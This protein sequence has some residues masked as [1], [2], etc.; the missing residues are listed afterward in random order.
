LCINNITKGPYSNHLNVNSNQTD[1]EGL[2]S[3]RQRKISTKVKDQSTE[4]KVTVYNEQQSTQ[5]TYHVWQ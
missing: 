3:L 2:E 4:R 5:T 1:D